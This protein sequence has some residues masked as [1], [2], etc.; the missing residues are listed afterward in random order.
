MSIRR[1]SALGLVVAVLVSACSATTTDTPTPTIEVMPAPTATV[2]PAATPSDSP[3]PAPASSPTPSPTPVQ[4]PTP[5]PPP[6]ADAPP[7]APTHVHVSVK[8]S[9]PGNVGYDTRADITITFHEDNPDGVTVRVYGVIPCLPKL[10]LEGE[11]CLSRGTPLPARTRD[12]VAKAPA[13]DGRVTWT[14]PAWEDIGGAVMAS[15]SQAY[16]AI[17]IAAYND[18]GHSRFV[19]VETS[20]YCDGCTY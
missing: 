10:K 3:T 16:E 15:S 20:H 8:N 7:A 4:T 2:E 11:P 1:L 18:A 13:A 17:V 19:I 12:F 5:T 6:A 14:W 9:D